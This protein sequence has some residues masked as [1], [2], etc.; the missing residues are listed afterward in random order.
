MREYSFYSSGIWS[1]MAM[2][3]LPLPLPE[4]ESL[5]DQADGY[6][7]L[8]LALG[9]SH[10]QGRRAARRSL[11]LRRLVLGDTHERLAVDLYHIALGLEATLEYQAA[12]EMLQDA[13]LL[14]EGRTVTG[15]DELLDCEIMVWTAM[16]RVLAATGE[17]VAAEDSLVEAKRLMQ[18]RGP[19][20]PF[21]REVLAFARLSVMPDK[22]V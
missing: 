6:L 15:Q 14:L 18:T 11:A 16:G 22:Q 13:V 8:S 2:A 9:H 17:V 19:S 12:V 4:D 20:R 1:L 3:S 10:P 21:G 7:A 5:L